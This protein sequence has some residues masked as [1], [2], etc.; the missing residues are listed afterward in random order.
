VKSKTLPCP[1]EKCKSDLAEYAAELRCLAECYS[2]DPKAS[3]RDYRR[4]QTLRGIAVMLRRAE[5]LL[6]ERLVNAAG[7]RR[8]ASPPRSKASGDCPERCVQSP[9]PQGP[10]CWGG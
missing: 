10:I 2:F 1:A 8:P 4:P 6:L 5:L 3:A 7:R 9:G